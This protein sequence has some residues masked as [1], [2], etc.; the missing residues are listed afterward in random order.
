VRTSLCA[1]PEGARTCADFE[2]AHLL[3]P[4]AT[5]ELPARC[6]DCVYSDDPITVG[7]YRVRGRK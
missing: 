4:I 7:V 3:E 6:H 5:A 1:S 2:E